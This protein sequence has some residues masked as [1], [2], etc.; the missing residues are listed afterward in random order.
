MKISTTQAFLL[1]AVLQLSLVCAQDAAEVPVDPNMLPN[2]DNQA[3]Y[4]FQP[5]ATFD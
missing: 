3:G 5:Y 2:S 1:A 4:E